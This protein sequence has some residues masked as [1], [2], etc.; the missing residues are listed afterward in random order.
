MK[1]VKDG[2]SRIAIIHN[3]SPLFNGD[4]GSG[5]SEIRKYIIE[6]DLLETII[7][8][9]NDIF[10][11]TGITTYLW[12]LDNN[13]PAHKKGKIQLIDANKV[14]KKM[15]KAL[16]NKRNEITPE[17]I[18]EI[19]RIY[20]EYVAKE[21]K[22]GECDLEVKIFNNDDFGYNKVTVLSP[23]KDE[24]GNLILD[25]KGKIQVDKDKTDTEII[26]F[27]VDFSDYMNKNVLPF[28]PDA[29]I[30]ENKTKIGYEIPFTRLFYKYIPP[31]PSEQIFEEIKRL[32]E[33]ETKLMKELF[34]E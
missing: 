10:Y 22:V 34:G 31:T 29:W 2:G 6:N 33:E 1:D 30:D 26:S 28:N 23:L 14:F 12:I 3:G 25:K 21:Y 7:S 24:N 27:G 5:P 9:P 8:L 20:G 18:K 32:E 15:R 4:A 19:T 13:K 17:Q 11:N 16:G